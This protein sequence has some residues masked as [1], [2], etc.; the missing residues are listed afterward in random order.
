MARA[1]QEIRR[2]LLCADPS[3]AEAIQNV[4]TRPAKRLRPLMAVLGTL[5][6]RGDLDRNTIR[7]AAAVEVLHLASLLHDDVIDQAGRRSGRPT[8]HLVLGNQPAILLGDFFFARAL[9]GAARNN[10]AHLRR[11]LT[12]A[13]DLVAGEFG[14]TVMTGHLP[15]VESYLSWIEAKTASLFALAASLC[16]N[17]DLQDYGHAF[18]LAYQLRDDLLDLTA[19]EAD[20][21]KPIMND[22]GRGLYT[23]PLIVACA[24]E[25]GSLGLVTAARPADPAWRRDLARLLCRTGA[26]DLSWD[27]CRD[28]AGRARQS[29]SDLPPSQAREALAA[30]ADWV[31]RPGRPEEN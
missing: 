19:T 18:G 2:L 12:A 21:G 15:R 17:H 9:S 6:A 1:E 23:Y 4:I 8:C 7:G 31:G 16:G 25:P 29:L 26:I 24:R 30:L 13:E 20:L 3:L 28:W 22:C 11:F 27:A 5:A 14:Q 10:L